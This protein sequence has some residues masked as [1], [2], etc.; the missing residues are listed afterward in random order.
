MTN[1]PQCGKPLPDNAA[2]CV[3]CGAK[4]AP[5]PDNLSMLPPSSGSR[6][7]FLNTGLGFILPAALL[8]IIFAASIF[9]P[10]FLMVQNLSNVLLQYVVLAVIA[11]AVVLSARAKGPDLSV[12][13]V[14][15]L[16]G[17][18]IGMVMQSG[19]SWLTGLLLAVMTAAVVGAVNGAVNAVI[20]FRSVMLTLVISA[21]VTLII[22]F[23]VRQ[24]VYALSGGAPII[25]Q[26]PFISLALAAVMLILAAFVLAF[27]VNFGT[28]LGLPLYRNN[29]SIGL[30]IAAYICSAVIAAF[31][32]GYMLVRIQA[33]VPTAG[34]G[35]ESY[36]LFVFACVISSR[37]LDNRV[38]PVLYAMLPALIWAL[39]SNIFNLLAVN[40][41]SQHIIFGVLAA[42]AL[43]IA[44]FSRYE[45]HPNT[46]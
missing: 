22:S 9:T 14:M 36:I 40:A 8:V 45:K 10:H 13:A 15:G 19:G 1:C 42:V 44:F 25:V 32:G 34:L 31:A 23:G 39:M 5:I 20:R 35:Y 28:K 46:L 16:S 17:I 41:Y 4:M 21:T 33:A 12:G 43:I 3:S 37:A 30:C 11:F 38:G 27:F 24:I 6:A 29:R 18:V 26:S 2:Y 7:T